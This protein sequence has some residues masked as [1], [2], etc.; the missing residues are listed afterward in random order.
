[1]KYR[2]LK[3]LNNII[4]KTREP[5]SRS[6]LEPVLNELFLTQR[7]LIISSDPSSDTDKN[8]GRNLPSSNFATRFLA[9]MFLGD[10]SKE[11]TE[12]ITRNYRQF[13]D[14]FLKHF[15][16]THF[17]KVYAGGNPGPF[18][19]KKFLIQEIDLFE[20]EIIISIGTKPVDFLI[21]KGKL[22]KR[23]NKI[24]NY[25]GIPLVVS[26]HPSRNW[27][28]YRRKEYKF[29]STWELIRKMCQ[30]SLEDRQKINR[31][32]KLDF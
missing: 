26:L 21:G 8:R 25:N 29:Y 17:S 19:A 3:Q 10:D 13:S 12:L 15:Y 23:V 14:I 16:W 20:P 5:G 27:N 2:K 32:K 28:L 4:R 31:L 9:L 6:K 22:I 7:Y 1:M 11:K 30:L 18:W 24:L